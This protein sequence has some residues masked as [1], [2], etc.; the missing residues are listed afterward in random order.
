M[1]DI[2]LLRAI[3]E[4]WADL[5]TPDV[6]WQIVT[7]LLC[8]GLAWW[9]AGRLRQ[10][11]RRG[12]EAREAAEPAFGR[13]LRFVGGGFERLLFPL[14]GLGLVLLG[15]AVLAQFQHVN[16]LQIAIPLLGAF[17]A[18]R[19]MVYLL[20]HVLA[21]GG[22]L[23][24]SERWIAIV[25][26]IGVALYFTG[27]LPEVVDALERITLSVGKQRVSLWLVMQGLFSVALTLLV[28]MWVS[29][30]IEQRLLAA[31]SLDMS[32]R[33]VSGRFVKALLVLVAVLL[34]LALVGID[35]TVL[36]VFGGA[37]GVGL[38]LGMQR[39]A[40]NYFAGFIIL[41]DRS[42]RIG[43]I[44]T[45]D[46]YN[47][48]VTQINT[49]YTVLKGQDG[50]EAIL[51]NE[52]LINSPISNLS[53]TTREIR[54]SLGVSVAYDSDLEQVKGM[55]LAAAAGHPRVLADPAPAVFLRQFGSDGLD[56]ELGFWIRDPEAGS[57]NV[58][59]DLN[60]AIWAEFQ[61]NGVQIPYPQREVR[62]LESRRD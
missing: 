14:L 33:V 15:R 40:S 44:I 27:L 62:L 2:P 4:P 56:L 6:L 21:P 23:A 50:T 8:V 26:W 28:S 20:R 52:L 59:S 18:I 37:L 32:F 25:V 10:R 61:A 1:K 51:P 53:F 13:Q 11:F 49:R 58:R 29:A 41:L 60:F 46:K 54:L 36:S 12:L 30:L 48:T 43:D 16:V 39:I 55:M 42:I 9:L 19:A 5:R 22:I 34:S 3:A 57:L 45:L 17:A 38:G 31:V 24:T 7:L 47:G 35:L